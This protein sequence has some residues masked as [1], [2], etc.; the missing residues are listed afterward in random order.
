MGIGLTWYN[1]IIFGALLIGTAPYLFGFKLDKGYFINL[2]IIFFGTIIEGLGAYLAYNGIN[3]TLLYNL[4][5]I[6]FETIL[7]LFY[8]SVILN[9][10]S[11]SKFLWTSIFTL[12]IWVVINSIFFQNINT[13][14]QSYAYVLSAFLVII[15]CFW[16][17]YQIIFRDKYKE[18]RLIFIPQFWAVS[19]I[20]F[21]YSSSFLYF[22]SMHLL[23]K[24]DYSAVSILGN[25]LLILSV[26][27]YCMM[28]LAYYLPYLEE[29]FYY[30]QK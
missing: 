25:I 29:K 18:D 11:Y 24:L 15:S 13:V 6:Y 19:F 1:Y 8:F 3:N 20:L 26:L 27:M 16:F 23:I 28:G 30:R 9:R 4:G 7:F 22:T 12:S 14:F 21:F 10:K 17:F 2:F 5:F